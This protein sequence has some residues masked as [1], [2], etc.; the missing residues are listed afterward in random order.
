MAGT[1]P[2][3]VLGGHVP[4]EWGLDMPTVERTVW[5]DRPRQTVWDHVTRPDLLPLWAAPVARASSDGEGP[6]GIGDRWTYEQQF[7]GVRLTQV[8]RV[9]EVVV[10]ERLRQR[11]TSG[12]F[13]WTLLVTLDTFDAGTGMTYR[14]EADEGLGGVFGQLTDGL[15]QRCCGAILLASLETLKELLEHSNGSARRANLS[16]HVLAE[17]QSR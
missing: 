15:V 8:S 14:L 17:D 2:R 12:P 7:L 4:A 6:V 10:P 16:E 9:E 11:S 1:L 3:T 13:D 5:I